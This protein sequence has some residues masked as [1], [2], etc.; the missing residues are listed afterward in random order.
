MSEDSIQ[1][2]IETLRHQIEQHNHQY[3]VLDA[4][5]IPDAE[6]DRLMRELTKLE[7]EH[8]ELVTAESP[9]QR[10]GGA[11]EERFDSVRHEL[12][13]L[14]LGNVFSEQELR[15]FDRR[16][17]ERLDV[18]TIVYSCEPKLDGVAL[19]LL[20]EGGRLVRAATRGDGQTGED[21]THTARVIPAVPL[22]LMDGAPQGR[23]EVRG[24][25]YMPKAGFAAYNK[26]AEA[27]GEKTFV[28]PRNAA[29]GTLRQL[30][31][32]LAAKRPLAF[33]AYSVGVVDG[34][35]LPSGHVA[36]LELLAEA[37]LPVC[38]HNQRVDGVEGC[39]AFYAE[40]TDKRDTLPYEIDG[41]VYKVDDYEQQR[42]LG[43]VS[44]APRWAT[45]HKFPAQEELTTV[46]D[47]DVQVGRTGAITP[48]ARLNPVF[49]GGVTVTNVTLHNEDEMRRKDVRIG[50]TVIVRR[51][52]DVIPEIVAVVPDRRP[53]DARLFTMPSQCP[54]CQSPVERVEGEAVARCT[55][56]LICAAQRKEAIRHFASRKALDIE[57]LGDKLID[58]LVEAETLNNVAD[59]FRLD[60]PTLAALDRMAE[61]SASNL[62]AAIETAKSTTL[63]RL[64]YGIGIREVG[65]ST[66]ANLARWFGRLEAIVEADQ[67]ALEAVPDV[68]PI[69]ASHI[70]AFFDNEDNLA[71]IASLRE[72]GVHW[73]Q[74]KP[75]RTQ[76]GPLTGQTI[77]LTGTLTSMKRSEAK[78][79]LEAL[80][81]KVSGSVSKATSLV[82]A[83]EK[84]GSKLTKA[85]ELGVEVG[86]EEK[87]AELLSIGKT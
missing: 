78:I 57:G 17:R 80:G 75:Q 69:V 26:R 82:I 68:G 55:G 86:G 41:I 77:V 10:V 49:V 43:F 39:L 61:K 74:K 8:P 72:L 27:A 11:V 18:D 56:G 15:D 37:G 52:G 35:W 2:R 71:V 83:G 45:A 12:P 20:Y 66:A 40:M 60:V 5:K 50:D 53:A 62:V 85:T 73:P 28:N 24:E 13:M 87:L 23:L 3:Y 46:A 38:P 65:E 70:R 32:Q 9:T 21:V 36:T 67:D 58:Q 25:V 19:S 81:A 63:Q 44:K 6:Y 54:V 47:I 51:A 42:E 30:D 64:L 4:P 7:S 22:R 48:V 34:D 31:P 79:A 1:Q 33:F 16:V 59:V 14:S 76:T 84:A 29:A